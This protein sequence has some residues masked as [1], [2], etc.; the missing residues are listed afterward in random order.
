GYMQEASKQLEDDRTALLLLVNEKTAG[1]IDA[2]LAHYETEIT[3]TPI[4][5]TKAKKAEESQLH[6]T[7]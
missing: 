5:E 6:T 7:Y 2:R 1:M 4:I 3:R